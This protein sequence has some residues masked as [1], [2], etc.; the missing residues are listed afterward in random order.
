MATIS[1]VSEHCRERTRSCSL[2]R[3]RAYVYGEM[4]INTDTLFGH[5]Q[6]TVAARDT[7][8]YFGGVNAVKITGDDLYL[9][10]TFAIDGQVI[11]RLTCIPGSLIRTSIGF[12]GSA[13]GTGFYTP[14][15]DKICVAIGGVPVCCFGASGLEVTHVMSP[16][17]TVDFGGATLVNISGIV[18]NPNSYSAVGTTVPTVGA[19]SV[20]AL[21]IPLTPTAGLSGTWELVTKVIYVLG[22]SG[23]ATSGVYTFRAIAYVTSGGS[24]TPTVSAPYDSTKYEAAPLLGAA[25]ALTPVAGAVNVTVTGVAGLTIAWQAMSDIVRVES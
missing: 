8:I 7:V 24:T 3:F 10:N 5:A 21:A 6:K 4:D 15:A 22:G 17:G 2:R 18:V 14:V 23:G 19:V 1:I 20:V 16:T 11:T 25:V 13:L 9:R 12:T